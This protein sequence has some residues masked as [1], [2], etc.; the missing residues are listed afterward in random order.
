MKSKFKEQ[1]NTLKQN[2]RL[3]LK[4]YNDLYYL[5]EFQEKNNVEIIY[6][7]DDGEKL[8]VSWNDRTE[9]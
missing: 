4:T 7:Y 3:P 8:E 1:L 2:E 9:H 5:N 6:H